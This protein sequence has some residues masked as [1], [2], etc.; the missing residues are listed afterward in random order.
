MNSK[1]TSRVYS[2]ENRTN[3]GL[4]YFKQNFLIKYV[5]IKLGYKDHYI[6]L[7]L[8]LKTHVLSICSNLLPFYFTC[9]L[10]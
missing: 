5:F 8:G 7:I 4:G 6:F 1:S 2:F 3:F 10:H 9:I